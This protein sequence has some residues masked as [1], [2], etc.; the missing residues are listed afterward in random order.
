MSTDNFFSVIIPT[1]NSAKYV[2]RTLESVI[3]QTYPHYEIIVVDDGSD[4]NTVEIIYNYFENFNSISYK[5]LQQKN[6]GAG[7]ARNRG[8]DN[9]KYDWIAFLDS[10]DLWNNNKLSDISD[11]INKNTN[12]NFFCHNECIIELD[13]GVTINNY[14]RNFDYSKSLVRQLYQRNYFSTSAVV[15]KKSV[16]LKHNGFN[17]SFRSAQDYEMWLRMSSDIKVKFVD[18]VLGTYIMRSGNISTSN[19]WSRLFNILRIK[20]IH[21]K[22]VNLYIF[23]KSSFLGIILHILVPILKKMKFI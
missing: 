21:R 9:A 11:D 14:S 15:V 12:R 19:Y 13:G 3:D 16:L 5:V 17:V 2:K 7:S 1:Y 10:D 6:Y 20:L 4:D 18:R 22:K 23:L 8:I